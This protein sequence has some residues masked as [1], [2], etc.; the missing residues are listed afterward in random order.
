MMMVYNAIVRY[1]DRGTLKKIAD[2]YYEGDLKSAMRSELGWVEESGITIE[3][4]DRVTGHPEYLEKCFPKRCAECR[5]AGVKCKLDMNMPCSPDCEGLDPDTGKPSGGK[6]C[7][8]CDARPVYKATIKTD[9]KEQSV[10]TNY[11]IW[12]TLILKN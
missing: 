12:K 11:L 4:L 8:G 6:A 5:D 10:L 9:A 1:D 7:E 2:E 3:V